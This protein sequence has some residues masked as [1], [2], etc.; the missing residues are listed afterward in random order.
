MPRAI[1]RL[2]GRAGPTPAPVVAPGEVAARRHPTTRASTRD[3]QRLR[4]AGEP[5]QSGEIAGPAL[6]AFRDGLQP[7]VRP[8]LAGPDDAPLVLD[9]A[10]LATAWN[11]PATACD[12]AAQSS[13]DRAPDA[14]S[15]TGRSNALVAAA[16]SRSSSTRP[17]AI[18]ADREAA[19][20]SSGARCSPRSAPSTTRRLAAIVLERYPNLEP[21][22]KPRAVELLTQRT[23]WSLALLDAIAAGR[24][25]ADGTER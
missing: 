24:V 4:D 18:V 3:R 14:G 19:P 15:A 11:D 21:G 20:P 25:P 2:L 7:V 23:A 6:E 1:E 9:A 17:S 22:F 16:T 10:S 8:L 12:G 13:A 5:V